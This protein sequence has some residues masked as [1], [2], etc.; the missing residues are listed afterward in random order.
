MIDLL[1]KIGNLMDLRYKAQCMGH[2]TQNVAW[3]W[4]KRALFAILVSCFLC[5]AYFVFAEDVS[6]EAT[7]DSNKI[8]MG[9]AG[10]LLLTV[11]GTQDVDKIDL[12]PIDGVEVRYVGPSTQVRVINGAYSTAKVFTYMLLPLKEGTFTIPPVEVD[13]KGQIYR[14]EPIVL[15]V[16]SASSEGDGQSGADPLS[17]PQSLSDKVRMIFSVPRNKCFVNEELP[18]VIKLYVQDVPMQDITLPDIR[19]DGFVLS[20]YVQPRQFE[21]TV[22]G[23]KFHVVEFVTRITPLHPGKLSVGPAV[24]TANLV[25]RTNVRRNP[26]GRRSGFNDDFFSGIFGGYE[27]KPITITARPIELEVEDLPQEGLPKS[28]SG[29]VGKFTFD[30]ELSPLKV[31]VGDPFT[32]RMVV[33]GVGNLR[34]VAMPVVQDEKLKVYEPQI[35]E[36]DGRKILEL[37]LIPIKEDVREIPAVVFSYFDVEEGRY[38][39]ITRGPFPVEVMPPEKG[40][41]FQAIG[42]SDKGASLVPESFGKD[43]VFIKDHPGAWQR[44]GSA[45]A[46]YGMFCAVLF[47]FLNGWISVLILI[48]HR[49]RMSLDTSYAR[50]AAAYK[51][52]RSGWK[53][54]ARWMTDHHSRE[55]YDALTNILRA[56]L[57]SKLEIASGEIGFEVLE[58]ALMLNKIDIKEIRKLEDLL[59]VADQVRFGRLS[60]GEKEMRQHY[61][62][63]EEVAEAIERRVR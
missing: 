23:R 58:N 18:A 61:L 27:K 31:K 63:V 12:P 41:E 45:F 44:K 16:L 62:D 51:E 17:D 22:D 20:D 5:P 57:V 52:F 48:L 56:Y 2:R 25:F 28:F 10:Q 53:S 29:G 13:I 3:H 39:T 60:M 42:F 55:F 21:E 1:R 35:K 14:S 7:V 37:V 30:A 19:Q 47:V 32:L 33:S 59:R 36:E 26:F 54:A 8:A 40:Q 46:R 11:H 34:A 24:I 38:Q 15:Q 4:G 50:R 6:L 49:R 9:T 43:I